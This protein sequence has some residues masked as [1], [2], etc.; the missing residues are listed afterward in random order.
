MGQANNRGTAAERREQ[1]LERELDT[2]ECLMFLSGEDGNLRVAFL[3][4]D[5]QPN[6]DSPAMVFAAYINA[7][8]EQL[9][10]E[11]MALHASYKAGIAPSGIVKHNPQRSIVDVDGKLLRSTDDVALVV[12]GGYDTSQRDYKCEP[13]SMCEHPNTVS[14]DPA[15]HGGMPFVCRACGVAFSR[16]ATPSSSKSDTAPS[17]QGDGGGE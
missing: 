4:R 6:V 2:A 16:A 15:S 12:T 1:S 5:E 9:A 13:P 17:G 14:V 8:W 7:N 3:P 11:A 10:G